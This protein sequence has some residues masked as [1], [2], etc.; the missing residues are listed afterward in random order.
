MQ[1][2][3]GKEL[4]ALLTRDAE[5]LVSSLTNASPARLESLIEQAAAH[6]VAPLLRYRLVRLSLFDC[7]PIPVRDALDALYLQESVR[8]LARYHE[9]KTMVDQLV[10]AGTRVIALK[11]IYLAKAVYTEPG[12]RPMGDM[13]LLFREEDLNDVQA[14]LI[15]LGYEREGMA[16][17]PSYYP[18][19]LHQLPPF[20]RDGATG[21]PPN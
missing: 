6:G 12:L 15:A 8:A 5:E 13:D 9:L 2:A 14:A 19:R 10:D 3:I 16:F 18:P 4:V 21:S 20:T 11:G 1:H 17:P 7:L